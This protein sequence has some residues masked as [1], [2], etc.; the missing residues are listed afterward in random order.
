MAIIIRRQ[1]KLVHD[2]DKAPTEPVD[3]GSGL[4]AEVAEIVK[5]LA[6][7]AARRDHMLYLEKQWSK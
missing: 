2:A 7:A 4:S 5:E 3:S 6:Y 1:L